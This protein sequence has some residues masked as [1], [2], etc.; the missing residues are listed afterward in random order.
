MSGWPI[1]VYLEQLQWISIHFIPTGSM[2]SSSSPS[3]SNDKPDDIL[4]S[5]FANFLFFFSLRINDIHANDIT[6]RETA[7]K[8]RNPR[9]FNGHRETAWQ[10]EVVVSTVGCL[11]LRGLTYF[12]FSFCLSC[13]ANIFSCCLTKSSL[14]AFISSR[15]TRPRKILRFTRRAAGRWKL[16]CCQKTEVMYGGHIVYIHNR[17]RV[18]HFSKGLA[19]SIQS[20]HTV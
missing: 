6:P 11:C 9:L 17:L 12:S 13:A 4:L 8:C 10:E 18:H 14:L 15:V 19:G 20:K 1:S 16:Q 2:S 7:W 3:I 5:F